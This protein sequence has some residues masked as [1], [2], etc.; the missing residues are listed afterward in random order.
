M[1]SNLPEPLF[2]SSCSGPGAKKSPAGLTFEQGL[3]VLYSGCTFVRP[4]LRNEP[5]R[6]HPAIVSDIKKRERENKDN[7][8]LQSSLLKS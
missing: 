1:Q 7:R 8:R 3:R 4:V 6:A 5:A 2:F